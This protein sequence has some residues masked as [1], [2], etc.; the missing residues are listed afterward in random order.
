MPPRYDSEGVITL[1]V[2][3]R[4][5]D[6][7]PKNRQEVPLNRAQALRE[8]KASLRRDLEWLLN[9][10][11][12]PVEAPEAF[13]EAQHS[14]YNYGLPDI[15]SVVVHSSQDQARLAKM[16]ETAIAYFEP[17]LANVKVAMV[18]VQGGGRRLRFVI[19][20]YLRIDPAPEH[21]SFDT[22]LELTSGEYEIK[23]EGSAR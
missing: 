12:T 1:T 5:I 22:T 17:R 11:R 20:G 2:L 15:T 18:P 21:I 9:S 3:D 8:L 7:E 14:L 6:N 23:K 16:L 10:R 4:L 19:E 13:V